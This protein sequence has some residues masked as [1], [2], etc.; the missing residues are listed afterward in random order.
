MNSILELDELDVERFPRGVISRARLTLVRDGMG[1]PVQLPILV[2]RGNKPGPVFGITA[3]LHG[4]EL[5]GIPVIHRVFDRLDP[6]AVRGTIV[7]IVVVNVPA[8]LRHERV[9]IDGRDLNRTMPGRP[10][11]NVSEVYAHRLIDRIVRHFDYLVDLHTASFG[12][13]NSLY[14]RADLRKDTTARMARLLR[15][16]II[17]HNPANDRTLRGAAEELGI[18]AVTLEI[19]DPQRFQ[20]EFIK[21]S[22]AGIRAVMAEVGVVP[23]K[24]Q[25]P[26]EPAIVC[27]SSAWMFTDLGGV[28]EV[29]P[30]VTERVAE[31]T[32]I[33]RLTNIFGD[34]RADY[35]AP[36]DCV[37]IGKSVNP[38]GHT[39]ARVAH[40]GVEAASDWTP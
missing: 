17:L 15:P 30:R 28:L 12:R 33:A 6:K 1:A 2:A 35:R 5:N 26:R 37:V 34:H 25:E 8:Y 20:G 18:P 3:A 9:Y 21:R 39:G 27:S 16:Q 32:A 11:G 4:N 10:D 19:G 24:A 38:V 31:G 22:R 13:I 23:R 7:A 29:F 14:V 40:L 36:H